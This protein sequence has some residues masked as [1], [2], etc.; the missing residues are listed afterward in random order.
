MN[1]IE[2]RAN[3]RRYYLD[4]GF[5]TVPVHVFFWETVFLWK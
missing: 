4:D 2:T 1:G 3:E 5:L